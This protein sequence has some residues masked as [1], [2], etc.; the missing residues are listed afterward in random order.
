M[1]QGLLRS[2]TVRP[3]ELGLDT[4]V[5]GRLKA[6]DGRVWPNLFT[7]DT[8]RIGKLWETTAAHEIRQQAAELAG[9]LVRGL[10]LR[11]AV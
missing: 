4:D 7:L 5:L 3:G 2:D 6:S 8:A 10:L 11:S 9:A 1:I